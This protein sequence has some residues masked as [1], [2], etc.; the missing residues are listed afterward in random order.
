[1]GGYIG[2][3]QPVSVED[4]SI[5]TADIVDGAVTAAKLAA[6]AAVP[7][8]TNQSGKYLTTDGTDASWASIAA[9]TFPFHKAD[10]SL[11]TIAITNGQF[12][13][14][15]ADGTLDNIGVS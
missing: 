15:K 5:E 7:S 13:F 9:T 14:Y 2:R 8:Q 11:D 6:G 4:N 1:M 12:P 3:G 10:G